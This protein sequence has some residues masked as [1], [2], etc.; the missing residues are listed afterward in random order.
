MPSS[1]IVPNLWIGDEYAARASEVHAFDTILNITFEVDKCSALAHGVK[2]RRFPVFDYVGGDKQQLRAMLEH[3][4]DACS[5]IERS[6]AA[7]RKV[8]VHCVKGKQRSCAVVAAY[9]IKAM[10]LTTSEA[11]DLIVAKRPEAFNFGRH[12]NFAPALQRWETIA[13]SEI[14]SRGASGS[15]GSNGSKVQQTKARTSVPFPVKN[16]RKR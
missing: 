7:G 5:A 13:T 2:F 9:L 12:V 15:K 1:E 14:D 3:F 10:G 11:R 8:L 6:I 4:P 16:A